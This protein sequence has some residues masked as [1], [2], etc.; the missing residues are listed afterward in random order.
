MSTLR[1]SR[2]QRRQ[3]SENSGT[4]RALHRRIINTLIMTQDFAKRTVSPKKPS[5]SSSTPASDSRRTKKA[6]SKTNKG[7]KPAPHKANTRKPPV[8]TSKKAPIW[9]WLVIGGLVGVFVMFLSHLAK[10]LP[11]HSTAT[12][13]EKNVSKKASENISTADTPKKDAQIKFD[14]YTILKNQ[15]VEVDEKVLA[16][17]PP[18]NNVLYLLQAASFKNATDA[19]SLRAKLLLL[20]LPAAVEKTHSKDNQEWHRVIAGPFKSRSKL[21]KAR[22]ILASNEINS[23][24]LKRKIKP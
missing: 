10:Q 4:I 5:T 20:G 22:S 17:T 11:D 19:D 2:R 3:H 21:A 8:S 13:A 1:K 16:N 24:L 9:A 15:E 6:S 12:T 7:K 23:I 18:K 14:F